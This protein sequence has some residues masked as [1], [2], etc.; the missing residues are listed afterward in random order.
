MTSKN[1]ENSRK[2]VPASLQKETLAALPKP[3]RLRV[4]GTTKLSKA[5]E[6]ILRRDGDRIADALFERAAEGN[7]SSAKLLIKIIEAEARRIRM[8]R[9]QD[10]ER[11][12][13][14]SS[15]SP[16]RLVP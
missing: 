2:E 16:A 15:R 4:P 7:V 6:K 11:K 8:Q 9:R 5:C 14:A 13:H 12:K 1:D 10:L 3:K